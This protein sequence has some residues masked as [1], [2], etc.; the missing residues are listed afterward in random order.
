M[1]QG[2][3]C[4]S[5]VLYSLLLVAAI[6]GMTPDS[7][8]LASLN[9]VRVVCPLLASPKSLATDDGLPDEVC[10]PT[11]CESKLSPRAALDASRPEWLLI[12]PANV[13]ASMSRSA[14]GEKRHAG[15][16]HGLDGLCRSLCRLR[17]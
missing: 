4:H 7:Q 9:A 13:S 2:R 17:C 12:V 16:F 14:A 3:R 8:D 1:C 5:V 11:L 6:Q 10:G 15:S